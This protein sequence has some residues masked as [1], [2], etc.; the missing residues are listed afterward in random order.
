MSSLE[1]LLFELLRQCVWYFDFDTLSTFFLVHRAT[2]VFAMEQ[3]FHTLVIRLK[4]MNLR[5]D[6]IGGSSAH[7]NDV[8][9]HETLSLPVANITINGEDGAS[10]LE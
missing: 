2:S 1:R 4:D 8:L 10:W 5:T 7:L 6:V 9:E 3:L